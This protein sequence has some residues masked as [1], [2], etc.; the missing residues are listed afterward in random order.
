MIGVK[1]LYVGKFNHKLG[2][3]PATHLDVDYTGRQYRMYTN[4]CTDGGVE[5]KRLQDINTLVDQLKMCGFST[6]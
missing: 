1:L 5:V 4:Y 2:Y 6:F 3:A